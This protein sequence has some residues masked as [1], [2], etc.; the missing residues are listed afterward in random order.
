MIWPSKTTQSK[1]GQIR[2]SVR[3]GL[4]H[5]HADSSGSYRGTHTLPAWRPSKDRAAAVDPQERPIN[6]LVTDRHSRQSRTQIRQGVHGANPTPEV[7][8]DTNQLR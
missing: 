5:K 4:A 2:A 6:H 7:L 3:P 8:D 1:Q